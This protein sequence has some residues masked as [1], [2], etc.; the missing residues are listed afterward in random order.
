MEGSE[1]LEQ[2]QQ[3]N[4]KKAGSTMVQAYTIRLRGLESCSVGKSTRC[5]QRH[6]ELNPE[7][8]SVT[9]V[10]E[11]LMPSFWPPLG[12]SILKVQIYRFWQNIHSQKIDCSFKNEA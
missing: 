6:W 7:L 12:T 4:N 3:R 8:L 2:G 10:L 11:D 9:L 1:S 5:F